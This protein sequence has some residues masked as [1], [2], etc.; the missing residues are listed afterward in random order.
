[1]QV[2]SR[3]RLAPEWDGRFTRMVA[4]SGLAHASTVVLALV[5]TVGFGLIGT[6]RVLGHKAAPVLRNL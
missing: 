1:M 2:T 6:W 4:L 5:L 3:L